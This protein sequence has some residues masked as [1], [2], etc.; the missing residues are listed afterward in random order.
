MRAFVFVLALCTPLVGLADAQSP[1]GLWRTEA[2]K[3]GAYVDVRI[4]P[5]GEA[6][7]GVI[8]AAHN[9]TRG[10]LVGEKLIEGMVPDGQGRW[11]SGTIV[12]P[13]T[14]KTY[15]GS[16]WMEGAGLKVRGCVAML[17][18]SQVWTRLE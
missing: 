14:E 1:E 10:D 17:C 16:M 2:V 12:A 6:L 3:N 5:C 11:D 15:A 4:A 18:R 9:T 8:E 13:D 7:C